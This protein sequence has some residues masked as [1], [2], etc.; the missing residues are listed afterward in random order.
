MVRRFFLILAVLA[1]SLNSSIAKASSLNIEVV[2]DA[3]GSMWA[4]MNGKMRF[5]RAQKAMD[6]FLERVPDT[7]SVGLRVYG[8]KERSSCGDTH[9]VVP[10]ATGNQREIR[11]AV[12]KIKPKGKTPLDRSLQA[13]ANDLRGKKG[14]KMI[15][16]LTDGKETCRGNPCQTARML[17]EKEGIQIDVIGMSIA[18]PKARKQLACIATVADGNY[19]DAL[20]QYE[21]DRSLAAVAPPPEP[22]TG[23]LAI[24]VNQPPGVSAPRSGIRIQIHK[25][26]SAE[27]MLQSAKDQNPVVA[28]LPKGEYRISVG[29]PSGQS[30]ESLVTVR[31]GAY[32]RTVF[33]FP[34]LDG[35]I[36]VDA[37]SRE[38]ILGTRV[39]C[40]A[41]DRDG[42]EVV[43][44][45][46]S[47]PMVTPP[48]QY[49][50]RCRLLASPALSE[51]WIRNVTVESG[52]TIRLRTEF[53]L[54]A[55]RVKA[56]G[57]VFVIGPHQIYRVSPPG[58]EQSPVA[59]NYCG[60]AVELPAG[61]YDVEVIAGTTGRKRIMRLTGLEVEGARLT[62]A[63]ADFRPGSLILDITTED[64]GV[65]NAAKF[66]VYTQGEH[67]QESQGWAFNGLPLQ[68][69]AGLYDTLV[70]YKPEQ[71]PEL[72][73]WLLGVSVTAGE[74]TR[75]PVEFA[76]GQLQVHIYAGGEDT[77][78]EGKAAFYLPGKTKYPVGKL[79]NHAL[80][81]VPTGTYDILASD[82]Y[83]RYSEWRR[84]VV[85]TRG[86]VTELTLDFPTG[87]ILAH[88][89]VEEEEQGSD[90]TYFVYPQ[91]EKTDQIAFAFSGK[92]IDLVP[93]LY[94]VKCTR[95]R[96]VKWRR[97]VFVE[98]L[99]TT[100]ISIDF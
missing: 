10:F 22:A 6:K 9:L 96:T 71:G 66:E 7:V 93:G 35:T 21:L 56:V 16:L 29:L 76:T 88:L 78:L 50:L 98:A 18:D 37:V 75:I 43:E 39:L 80:L 54:G 68:L 26:G 67:D 65:G 72:R 77:R 30:K 41:L 91:G 73:Q 25:E 14:K 79:K 36:L 42:K 4:K 92:P 2:Y 64:R 59:W 17:A 3:S 70:Q 27:E 81:I 100:E 1:V 5:Q 74:R 55:L 85:V 95:G 11:A 89:T 49:D 97:N 28:E 15:V 47:L 62:E 38:A 13:A 46:S 69:P 51:T 32:Q 87:Q 44:E 8:N 83:L 99:E 63:V 31:G 94:D 53:Q 33:D 58:E 40:T 82:S 45:Y 24:K 86:R 61:R 84:G 57:E 60:T 23:K 52:K 90:L 19:F 20:N 12:R 34:T 48:G